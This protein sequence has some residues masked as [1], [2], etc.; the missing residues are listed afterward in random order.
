M[1][2]KIIAICMM[3]TLFLTACSGNKTAK[4][5]VDKI[6]EKGEIVLGVSAEF[7]PF[8]THKMIDGKDQI[9]GIDIDLA[10]EIA[11]ELNVNLKIVDNYFNVLLT[12]LNTGAYDFVI[13][14]VNPT[15]KRAKEVD[16]SDKYYKADSLL[17]VR[18][19]FDKTIKDIKDIDEDFKFGTQLGSL[20]EESIKK[21]WPKNKLNSLPRFPEVVMELKSG[22]ID[23]ILFDAPVAKNYVKNNP[24]LKVLENFKIE[25]NDMAIAI[26]KG[27]KELLDICNKVIK[28][29]KDNKKLDEIIKKNEEELKN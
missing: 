9:V 7:P 1:K 4:S 25:D 28:E 15:E 5:T 3:F 21:Y 18:K 10:K 29:L 12:G 8:E 6:K 26:K 23:G 17:V 11:K 14:G 16:F 27:N 2:K 24:D 19:D 20:Q 13:S 22:K